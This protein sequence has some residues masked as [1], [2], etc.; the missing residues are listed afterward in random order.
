MIAARCEPQYLCPGNHVIVLTEVPV[1]SGPKSR[2]PE[3]PS[4]GG[5]RPFI[6]SLIPPNNEP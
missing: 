1:S 5:F 3:T 6:N 4:V 2:K